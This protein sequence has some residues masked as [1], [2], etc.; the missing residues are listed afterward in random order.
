MSSERDLIE[1]GLAQPVADAE[2]AVWGFT[3][4]TDI[5]T[6]ESRRAELVRCARQKQVCSTRPSIPKRRSV[7]HADANPTVLGAESGAG[8][9]CRPSGPSR[10]LGARCRCLSG[11]AGP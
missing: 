6:L 9:V 3:N 10:S 11:V 7:Y 4:S 1:R 2:R 5:V 8:H